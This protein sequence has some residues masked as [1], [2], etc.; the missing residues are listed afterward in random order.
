MNKVKYGLENVY[1]A[2][3]ERTQG[4]NGKVTVNYGTPKKL[5][6][7][8]ELSLEPQGESEA[9]YADNIA[10][11]NVDSNLGY[12]GTLTLALIT[13]EFKKE[14][15]GYVED[16]N[17]VL[18]ENK[19]ATFKPFA[20][21]FEFKGDTKKTR[22]VLYNVNTSRGKVAGKTVADKTEVETEE[23]SLKATPCEETGMVKA[24]CYEGTEQ[25]NSW[26]STVY[27]YVQPTEAEEI[28]L[29]EEARSIKPK[30]EEKK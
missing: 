25:Y 6:G 1:Y 4:G 11:Y 9:F 28:K 15:M 18:F 7:T 16:K 12:E 14:I 17:R 26:F 20:L 5:N 10:Y 23:L 8:V 27:K 13:D 19:D 30:N 3:L 24:S 21:M 2:P 29:N 22:H